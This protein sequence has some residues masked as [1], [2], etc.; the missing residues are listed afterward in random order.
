MGGGAGLK[1]F[2]TAI[3]TSLAV[4]LTL[5]AWSGDYWRTAGFG[6]VLVCALVVR[7][8]FTRTTP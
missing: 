4:M 1:I 7:D 3:L 2:Y 8:D 6:L 5:E